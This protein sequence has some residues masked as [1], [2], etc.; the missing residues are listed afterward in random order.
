[1]DDTNEQTPEA[2]VEEVETPETEITDWEA[3]AK[4]ARGIAARLRTKLMKATE[5]KKA[6]E[7]PK[8]D[9]NTRE[10]DNADYALLMASGIKEDDEIE[11][12]EKYMKKWDIPLRQVLKDSDIQEKLKGLKLERDVKNAMPSATKRGSSGQIDNIDYWVTK[13]ETTGELP[14]NFE[15][16]SAV[17][18]SKV[19]R[20]SANQPPWRRK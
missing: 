14:D 17:I 18:N 11:L 13:Y 6:P 10:L 20:Y 4:K 3:E 9:S 5:A 16:R 15:L 7:A 19:Q 1:M 2:E 12:V 8:Q